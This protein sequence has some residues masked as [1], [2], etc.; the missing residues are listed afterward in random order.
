M[1]AAFRD[2]VGSALAFRGLRKTA[3]RRIHLVVAITANT[4][5]HQRAVSRGY[6]AHP[7][8]IAAG[9]LVARNEQ[10]HTIDRQFTSSAAGQRTKPRCMFSDHVRT[11]AVRRV[12]HMPPFAD[13]RS[14]SYEPGSFSWLLAA[15]R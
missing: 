11:V 5:G 1:H 10:P 9:R 3:S 2:G 13:R 4:A 7:N 14:W 12:R 6:E 15:R 8:E